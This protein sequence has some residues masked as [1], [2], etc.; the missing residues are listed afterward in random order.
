MRYLPSKSLQRT[1]RPVLS[2]S[3]ERAADPGAGQRRALG[4]RLAART[5]QAWRRIARLRR[6][7]ASWSWRR[8]SCSAKHALRKGEPARPRVC[9][10]AVAG[11]RITWS[12]GANAIARMLGLLAAAALVVPGPAAAQFSKGYKF[13]EAIRKKD[14]NAV[15]DAL[16]EPGSTIVN[17]RDSTTGETALHI[18]TSPARSDLDELPRRQGRQRQRPR[19][20]RRDAAPDRRQ[21]RLP[22]EG[23][24]LLVGQKARIDEPNAAGETPLITADPPPQYRDR[25]RA[26]QGWRRSRPGGQ[27]GPQRARLCAARRAQ[28][29]AGL[30]RSKPMPSPGASA[31]ALPRPT[32]PTF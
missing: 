17:T 4:G 16:N 11:G 20:P 27:F 5:R 6:K 21:S 18:V 8:G 31:P 3:V 26:A 9:A 1:V 14:G 10:G 13:L 22:V 32:G 30:A 28:F 23:V 7:A 12:S 29:R 19:R 2:T 25:A 15:N 24:E